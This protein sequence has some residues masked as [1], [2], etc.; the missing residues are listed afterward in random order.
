M[1]RWPIHGR[2]AITAAMATIPRVTPRVP[3]MVPHEIA[4]SFARQC[5]EHFG[6]AGLDPVLVAPAAASSRITRTALYAATLR[7]AEYAIAGAPMRM[8][9]ARAMEPLLPIVRSPL[10]PDAT[11]HSAMQSV[12]PQTRQGTAIAMVLVAAVARDALEHGQSVTST[13]LAVMAGV[14]RTTIGK[15]V[16]AQRLP[17]AAREKRGKASPYV[18]PAKSAVAWLESR[19]VPGI[20]AHR[21]K[22]SRARTTREAPRIPSR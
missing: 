2:R 21:P 22:Q 14:S 7:L 1:L 3:D 4:E 9:L 5:V 18:V 12:D 16:R 19:G 10:T 11:M 17:G 13:E 15:D 8:S 20:R 6:G